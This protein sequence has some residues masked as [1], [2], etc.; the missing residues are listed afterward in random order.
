MIRSRASSKLSALRK[1]VR[2]SAVAALIVTTG[3]AAVVAPAT[4]TTPSGSTATSDPPSETAPPNL[5]V[6][7]G[8]VIDSS[9]QS[10]LSGFGF[11][12]VGSTGR[13][14]LAT[15]SESARYSI[16][17][18][19]GVYHVQARNTGYLVVV[20]TV[21]TDQNPRIN[22]ERDGL[23]NL[24]AEPRVLP[25]TP[26]PS[27]PTAPDESYSV[28]GRV[29][30]ASGHLVAGVGMELQ[31]FPDDWNT[32][33]TTGA[34]GTFTFSNVPAGTYKLFAY[35]IGAVF[36]LNGNSGGSVEVPPGGSFTFQQPAGQT[37]P[38]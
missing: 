28:S 7:S 30:S 31:R 35:Q 2:L 33:V 23:L 32:E 24:L 21:P 13:R 37:C 18:P 26:A 11:Y 3:C 29:L 36:C 17:V 16:I 1:A 20:A 14:Y 12:F 6:I 4:P 15:S 25:S 19:F 10:G 38:Y 8:M 34:D 27:T 22:V 9:T 5:A